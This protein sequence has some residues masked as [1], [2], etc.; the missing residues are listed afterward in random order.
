MLV[1]AAPSVVPNVQADRQVPM[2][3]QAERDAIAA[4]R[5]EMEALSQL[6][7][8]LDVLTGSLKNMIE[9][10]TGLSKMVSASTIRVCIAMT[11][12]YM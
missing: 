5:A 3:S 11:L 2:V 9:R 10:A 8:N 12:Y 6:G 4:Q 1:L 7:L